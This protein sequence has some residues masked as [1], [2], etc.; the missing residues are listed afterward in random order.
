MKFKLSQLFKKK[1]TPRFTFL[2]IGFH[3]DTYLINVVKQLQRQMNV[4]VETGS[5]VATT[6]AFVAKNNPDVQC[7]SCEPDDQAYAHA[8]NNTKHYPNVTLYKQLSQDF[9]KTLKEKHTD[10]FDK[11]VVF[12]IDAHSYGFDWPLQLEIEFITSNFK[13]YF[14][15]IDDF[16]VPHL[17]EFNF[18]VYKDQICSFEY[19]KDYIASD[20][21]ALYYPNYIEKTSKHHPLQGWGLISSENVN[22]DENVKKYIKI[23]RE[24]K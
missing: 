15:L 17:P 14:I 3:G 4:F 11:N 16:K 2:D 19:I 10:I 23:E 22:F 20:N 13:N 12:W 8:I 24:V 9:L 7:I 6:L 21:Y 1:S 5:N 18:D